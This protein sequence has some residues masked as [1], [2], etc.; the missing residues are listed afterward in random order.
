[1]YH[2][3]NIKPNTLYRCPRLQYAQWSNVKQWKM[4]EGS[5]KV[6]KKIFSA[7][8][9]RLIKATTYGRGSG[10]GRDVSSVPTCSRWHVFMCLVGDASTGLRGQRSFHRGKT[11]IIEPNKKRGRDW[12]TDGRK[13]G[14]IKVR[15]EGD[16]G[17]GEWRKSA[18]SGE[19]VR[20]L[21]LAAEQSSSVIRAKV[22]SLEALTAVLPS[23]CLRNP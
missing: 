5:S 4:S 2:C 9:H 15:F 22:K 11:L 3:G 6:V 17:E 18:E 1:M 19:Q 8:N 10:G 16:K 20:Q 23:L 13:G 7:D 21:L 14:D 12:C